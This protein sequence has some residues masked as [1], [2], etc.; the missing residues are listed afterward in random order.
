MHTL[1]GWPANGVLLTRIIMS[2][3]KS[4]PF[5]VYLEILKYIKIL[6]KKK[7]T[8]YTLAKHRR[9][10]VKNMLRKYEFRPYMY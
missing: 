3:F 7:I 9:N 4:L 5:V 6:E 10:G 2:G 8:L 1:L